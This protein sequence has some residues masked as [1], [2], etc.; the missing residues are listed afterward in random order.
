MTQFKHGDFVQVRKV[1]PD[2]LKIEEPPKKKVRMIWVNALYAHSYKNGHMVQYADG[3][4][5]AI[6]NYKDR[7][8]IRPAK[9]E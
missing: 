2:D 8:R 4:R 5:E 1:N 6:G 3:T 9:K 7:Q